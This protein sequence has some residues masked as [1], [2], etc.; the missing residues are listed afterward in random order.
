[1]KRNK[2][3]KHLFECGW[4]I[5]DIANKLDMKPNTVKGRL[6]KMRKKG[7]IIEREM[8][9]EIRKIFVLID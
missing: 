8:V 2:E 4:K 1:M 5:K 7:I 6:Y 9:Y 3:I